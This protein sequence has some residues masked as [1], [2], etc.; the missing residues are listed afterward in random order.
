LRR[1]DHN[2]EAA[3]PLG[4][5]LKKT[6]ESLEK[7]NAPELNWH[8]PRWT[9]EVPVMEA[10]AEASIHLRESELSRISDLCESISDIWL[11]CWQRAWDKNPDISKH[12]SSVRKNLGP[13]ARCLGDSGKA[14]LAWEGY[15]PMPIAESVDPAVAEA[16]GGIPRELRQVRFATA[17][18]AY[19]AGLGGILLSKKPCRFKDF[20]PVG[21]ERSQKASPDQFE[22]E[23]RAP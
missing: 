12:I 13:Y 19:V 6:G 23:V 11:A 16:L 9:D 22:R 4:Y 8:E 18:D 21:A 15:D 10:V 17:R 14:L 7:L 3:R 20:V 5:L 1:A 2:R